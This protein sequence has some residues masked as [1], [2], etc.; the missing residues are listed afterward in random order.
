MPP[1]KAKKAEV[2]ERRA[3]LIRLRRQGIPFEDPRILGLGYKSRTSA[4]KDMIRALEERRD[5]WKAEVSVYRQEENERL[6]ALLL[7]V[8]PHAT[9][10]IR[11]VVNRDDPDAE[12]ETKFDPR[13]VDT[14]IK[15]LERR[16]K[17]NGLDMPAKTELS[18]PDGADLPMS[19]G[20]LAT[21]YKLINVAGQA[22]H[23]HLEPDPE[24]DDADEGERAEA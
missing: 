10:P 4:T 14:A 16:A 15:L 12:P 11:E 7:A 21:L 18:G 9:N 23:P 2:A 20:S 3:A 19:D 22:G 8:W 24:E 6:D 13:A 5:D 17:L 1:T